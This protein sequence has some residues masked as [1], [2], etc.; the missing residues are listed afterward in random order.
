METV[1]YSWLS[2]FQPRF[3]PPWAE[4]SRAMGY[5]DHHIFILYP[6][7]AKIQP[8]MVRIVTSHG[9]WK[10]LRQWL[11]RTPTMES[12]LDPHGARRLQPIPRAR[13]A[14]TPHTV[15]TQDC[16]HI[17]R[18]R[19]RWLVPGSSPSA[20]RPPPQRLTSS[21][22]P[23]TAAPRRLDH[24]TFATATAGCHCYCRRPPRLLAATVAAGCQRLLSLLAASQLLSRSL[25]FHS[26]GHG[27]HRGPRRH[28]RCRHRHHLHQDA[29]TVVTS[30]LWP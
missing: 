10:L 12:R 6:F 18:G 16:G 30:P 3:S 21:T 29:G 4:F 8:A 5:G 2:L 26:R 9:V 1:I 11:T 23:A 17:A 13:R 19:L 24:P 15:T 25:D 7:S 20:I 14:T 27:A 28:R 22:K